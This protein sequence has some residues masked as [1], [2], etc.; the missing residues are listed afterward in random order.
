MASAFF[1]PLGNAHARNAGHA[2]DAALRIAL[3]QQFVDLRVLHSL[4]H[5]SGHK[6][7]LVAARFALVTGVTLAV[8]VP[9]N[10][11]AAAFGAEVLRINHDAHYGFHPKLDHRRF[12]MKEK[13]NAAS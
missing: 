5:G 2:Y 11:V 10:L 13:L 1:Y 7:R 8:P 4:G 12:W 3:A 6:T 9:S